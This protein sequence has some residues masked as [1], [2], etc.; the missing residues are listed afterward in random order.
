M[1]SFELDWVSFWGFFLPTLSD[2]LAIQGVYEL[3]DQPTYLYASEAKTSFL[4]LNTF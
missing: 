1:R 4:T 3:S 2:L